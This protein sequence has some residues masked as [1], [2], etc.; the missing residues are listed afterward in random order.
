MTRLPGYLL[1][2]DAAIALFGGNPTARTLL[3]AADQ[4]H[5]LVYIPASVLAEVRATAGEWEP[6]L[7]VPGVHVLP[8]SEQVALALDDVAESL[9]DRHA[10]YEATLLG[11]TVVTAGGQPWWGKGRPVLTI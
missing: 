1:T 2:L 6:I 4:G 9:D 8:L 10:A 7:M 5:A 11:A 3:D